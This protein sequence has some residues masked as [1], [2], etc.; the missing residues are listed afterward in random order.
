MIKKLRTN[1]GITME[2]LGKEIGVTKSRINMWENSGV[3]P[4]DEILLKLSK[5]FSVST[6]SLLGNDHRHDARLRCE[7]RVAG[8]QRHRHS[9]WTLPASDLY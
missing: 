3:V 9:A 7:S 4:H 8:Q 5:Y 6:D 1:K 2:M